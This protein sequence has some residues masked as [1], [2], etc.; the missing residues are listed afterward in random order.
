MCH[1]NHNPFKLEDVENKTKSIGPSRSVLSIIPQAAAFQDFREEF[2][3]ILLEIPGIE[4]GTFCVPSRCSTTEPHHLGP[5]CHNVQ[6]TNMFPSINKIFL[7]QTHMS[8]Q[9]QGVNPRKGGLNYLFGSLLILKRQFFPKRSQTLQAWLCVPCLPHTSQK[10]SWKKTA[11]RWKYMFLT[12][13]NLQPTLQKRCRLWG[14]YAQGKTKATINKLVAANM[15]YCLYLSAK[16]QSKWGTEDIDLSSS[17]WR[18]SV[19]NSTI[20]CMSHFIHCWFPGK[21]V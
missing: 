3:S 17:V 12:T 18:C 7:S 10:F 15:V 5:E 6:F 21:F 13:Y 14:S 2:L 20:L 1:N 19:A 16:R 4:P 8:L 11:H 9:H